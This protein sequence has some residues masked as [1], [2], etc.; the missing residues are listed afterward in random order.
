MSTFLDTQVISKAFKGIATPLQEGASI[1]SIVANEFLL[2]QHRS[3]TKANYYIRRHRHWAGSLGAST[4]ETELP[5]SD[6][7]ASKRS[8]DALHIDFAGQ[9]PS[10]I[11]FNS[12]S[13]SYAINCARIRSFTSAVRFLP[14]RTAKLLVRRFKFVIAARVVCVPITTHDIQLGFTLLKQ[15]IEK[16][17]PKKNFRNTWNDILI[18]LTVRSSV[19]GF[20][21]PMLPSSRDDGHARRLSSSHRGFLREAYPI[22]L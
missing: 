3:L 22:C 2:V 16:H 4:E 15:F 19:I 9:F 21:R 18:L 5:R 1:S 10:I 8:T 20:R 13:V 14:S 6:H 17:K 7:S 11:E 12:L